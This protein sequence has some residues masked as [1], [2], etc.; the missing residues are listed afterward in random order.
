MC[1]QIISPDN[2]ITID[3][4]DDIFVVWDI[5][6]SCLI[7]DLDQFG[8]T[9]WPKWSLSSSINARYI[10]QKFNRGTEDYE[11]VAYALE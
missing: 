1:C 7:G 5:E 3:P 10:N 6:K 4:A 8:E 11:R 2:N 9:L